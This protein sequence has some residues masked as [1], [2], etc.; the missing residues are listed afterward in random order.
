MPIC[1][2][3][4]EDKDSLIEGILIFSNPPCLPEYP[5]I[6]SILILIVDLRT[7]ITWNILSLLQRA[8]SNLHSS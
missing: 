8:N 7:Y 5:V 1:F 3:L 4:K 2:V 6:D